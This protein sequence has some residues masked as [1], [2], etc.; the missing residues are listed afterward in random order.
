[1][2]ERRRHLLV[3]L[4]TSVLVS[5]AVSSTAVV[6]ATQINGA[7]LI[8]RSVKAVKVARN[9]LTG[10]ELNESTL[11]IVPSARSAQRIG[12]TSEAQ[13]LSKAGSWS[14]AVPVSAM[15]YHD[16]SEA[17]FS[18]AK[19][20]QNDIVSVSYSSIPDNPD[21]Q[22]GDGEAAVG[23]VMPFQPLV[24][25]AGRDVQVTGFSICASTALQLQLTPQFGEAFFQDFTVLQTL[26]PF[27]PDA[28]AAEGSCHEVA[29]N[30]AVTVQPHRRYFMR[31]NATMVDGDM[32]RAYGAVVHYELA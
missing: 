30:A 27:T 14:Q 12:E 16:Y 5:L 29:L 24:D 1:M 8:N 21:D 25:V 20:V 11:G 4:C 17:G 18:F 28:M 7:Q 22:A 15:A 32:L 3:T 10:A 2:N 23:L 9:S 13:L 31:L 26:A 6:A 19:G